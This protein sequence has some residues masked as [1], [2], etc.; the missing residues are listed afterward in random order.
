MTTRREFLFAVATGI[1]IP[2]L[3]PATVP[4]VNDDDG[5]GYC[6]SSYNYGYSE[7]GSGQY[8]PHSTSYYDYYNGPCSSV[9]SSYEG[10]FSSE[11]K[12]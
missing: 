2:K 11:A 9:R 5:D 12:P 10:P 4:V 6:S 8:S 7:P 1:I 3:T